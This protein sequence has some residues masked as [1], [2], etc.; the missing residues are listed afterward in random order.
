MEFQWGFNTVIGVAGFLMGWVLNNL[1]DSMKELREADMEL[2]T[3]VQQI[4]VLVAGTYVKRD[5]FEKVADAI[6]MK[7][8]KIENLLHTKADKYNDNKVY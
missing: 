4:E 3:K 2:T 1:R 5:A 7:L 6:F 8:D